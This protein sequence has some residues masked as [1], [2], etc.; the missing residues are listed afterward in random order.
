MQIPPRTGRINRKRLLLLH[1]N[2]KE[3]MAAKRILFIAHHR[4]GRSPSQRFRF[5][6][7]ESYFEQEGFECHSSHIISEQDDRVL[8][9]PGHYIQKSL[10]LLTCFFKRCRDLFKLKHYDLLFINA[11]PL[12]ERLYSSVYLNAQENPSFLTSMMLSGF[13]IFRKETN[14]LPF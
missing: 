1:S 14:T 13:W 7:F 3:S 5:E 8:Y 12:L 10:I 11:K 9:A 2:F 4:K 6:Q